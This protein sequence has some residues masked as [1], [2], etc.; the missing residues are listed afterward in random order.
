M[1]LLS[2]IFALANLSFLSAFAQ[3]SVYC[4]DLHQPDFEQYTL[5]NQGIEGKK[6]IMLGE[7]HYMAANSTIQTG[8]WIYLNQRFG[9]RHL[10]I[11]FGQ[12]EAYLYNQY[13]QTG[14]EWYINHTFQGFSG[15]VEFIS[16]WRKL[17]EYNLGL[18]SSKKLVVNGLD[19]ERDPG[20]SATMY[21]LL[22]PYQADPEINNLRDSIKA[23]L[24]TIGVERDTKEYIYHLRSRVSTLPLPDD[25]NKQIINDIL[26]NQSFVSSMEKRD[27]LMAE[28]FLALD[29]ADEVYFGQFGFAHAMLSSRNGLAAILNNSE[30]YRNQVLVMNMYY[31]NSDNSHPFEGLSDCPVFLYRI[32]PDNEEWGGFAKRGQWAWV[33]KDQSRYTQQE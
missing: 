24:D 9:V 7:M 17:Y 30:E 22:S 33:L 20:L 4:V 13:L 6:L 18:D 28:S 3:D 2:L 27:S 14:D 1:K 8:L 16:A 10:L 12:A 21:K 25:E 19:L 31:V 15:Y 5:L 32:D 29:T 11:E 26:N 23:R